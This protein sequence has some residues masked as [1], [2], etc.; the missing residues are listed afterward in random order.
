MANPSFFSLGLAFLLFSVQFAKEGEKEGEGEYEHYKGG[1]GE[2]AEKI[3]SILRP[4]VRR[5]SLHS[6]LHRHR[7]SFSGPEPSRRLLLLLLLLLR[8][9]PTART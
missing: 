8:R 7:T 6:L 9:R 5:P 3:E 2:E 4:S 1:G